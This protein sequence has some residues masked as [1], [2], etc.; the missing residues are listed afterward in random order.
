MKKDSLVI[1]WLVPEPFPGAGGDIGLFRIIRHLAE[2][3]HECQ[4]HVVPYDLMNA[5]STEQIREYVHEYFGPTPATY[6]KFDGAVGDAD[7]TFATFWPTAE[8]LQ[9]LTN[10][11]RRY[12]LVQ[13]LEP[14]FYPDDKQ[15]IERA[16]NTY[17]AG[18]HCVTLGPWLA[19]LL[20]EQYG[21]TADHF[22][23][24]VDRKIYWPRPQLRSVRRRLCFYAR[25]TTPRRAYDVGIAALGLVQTRLPDVEIIL[26]GAAELNPTP[27][28]RWVNRGL[29]AQEELATLFSGCDVGL[30]LSLTNLSFVPLEMMACRCAVVE[31]ASERVAGILTHGKDAWLV[32]PNAAAIADGVIELLTNRTLRERLVAKAD[33]RTRTMSWSHSARQVERILLRRS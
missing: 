25:P 20:R 11:G 14:S 31:L 10:G 1:N 27:Q 19:K 13:D 33:R 22:D 21:A 16:E 24:A 12:Y 9:R 5:F 8:N 32:Q 23:F 18:F 26:F 28:F 15:L 7:C 3:G 30:V 17:R 2:F 29:L 6:H 4:V